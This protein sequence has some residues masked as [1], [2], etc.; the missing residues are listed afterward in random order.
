MPL[1]AVDAMGGDSAPREIVE[2]ALIAAGNGVEVV[3]VG[4]ES[5]IAPLV[6]GRGVSVSIR[7]ASETISMDDDPAHAIREKRDASIV[8]ASKMVASGEAD[9][10]VSAGSTGAAIACAAFLIGR[11]QGVARP[12]IASIFPTGHIVMD[13]GANIECKPE[14]LVQFAVMGS[15]LA[16][17]YQDKQSPR[18]GLLNIGEEDSKGRDLEKMAFKLLSESAGV[19]F[20]GNVEGRDLGTDAADVFVTDGFTGNVFL[21]TGEGTGKLIQKMMLDML[22]A[23]QYQD[24]VASLMP[25][26]MALRERLSPESVGGAHLVGTKGVVVI[27]HGSSSRI[28]IDNAIEIAAKGVEHGLVESIAAGIA[29]EH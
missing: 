22:A 27:G 9:A 19:N 28:A 14:H 23:P 5:Q 17:V 25:A 13:V 6:D 21:K 18:V 3:L 24:A 29:A 1:I 11:I 7:H 26:F 2:G 8:V 16:K 15:S 20:I 4:D 10:V 12:G